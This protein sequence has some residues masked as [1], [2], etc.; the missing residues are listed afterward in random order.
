MSLWSWY[1]Q[2]LRGKW[3]TVPLQPQGEAG[4]EVHVPADR[5]AHPGV[6]GPSSGQGQGFG[7]ASPE[8][9]FGA[10]VGVVA[11]SDEPQDAGELFLHCLVLDRNQSLLM[12][13][14]KPRGMELAPGPH[15]TVG[16]DQPPA[17]GLTT[18]LPN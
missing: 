12:G 16:W 7:K 15:P 13:T 17:Q 4:P 6:P 10:G 18:A 3:N 11:D 14:C 8:P 5:H 1:L 2:E 9:G